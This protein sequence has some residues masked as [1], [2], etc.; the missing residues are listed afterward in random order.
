MS[1]TPVDADGDADPLVRDQPL[2]QQRDR[3]H[4]GEERM[5]RRDEAG[6]PRTEPLRDGP[7]DAAEVD[8]VQQ[9]SG[10]DRVAPGLRVTRPG[11]SHCER[12][13]REP[14]RCCTRG[15]PQEK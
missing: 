4:R 7:E 13:H 3:E 9:H 8:A 6:E 1:P 5:E 2:V 12:E 10:H 15:G 14:P 11:S